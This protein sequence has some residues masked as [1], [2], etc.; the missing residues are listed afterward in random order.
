M[1]VKPRRRGAGCGRG[2]RGEGGWGAALRRRAGEGRGPASGLREPVSAGS[3]G[4]W[5]TSP[6]SRP[7]QADPEPRRAQVSAGKGG[8]GAGVGLRRAAASGG[9]PEVVPGEGGV[10]VEGRERRIP[11]AFPQ[12][13]GGREAGRGAA[14]S[15]LCRQVR[16]GSAEGSPRDLQPRGGR[17][18]ERSSGGPGAPPRLAGGLQGRTWRWK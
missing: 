10:C 6:V 17:V 8:A 18:A 11:P 2:R 13:G 4:G 14:P 9:L 5:A 7:V 16:R 12:A 1:Q 15:P 3:G